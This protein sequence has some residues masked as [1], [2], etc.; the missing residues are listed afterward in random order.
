MPFKC[1]FPGLWGEKIRFLQQIQYLEVKGNNREEEIMKDKQSNNREPDGKR[2]LPPPPVPPSPWRSS[3]GGR[4]MA[5]CSPWGG[6]HTSEYLGPPTP[7]PIQRL[8]E[9][10]AGLAFVLSSVAGPGW[11][12]CVLVPRAGS[13]AARHGVRGPVTSTQ[14][15]ALAH[16]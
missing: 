16:Q 3:T 7:Y 9:K 12:T 4:G 13:T 15:S 14:C 1:P 2:L 10:A 6:C 5:L 8:K 11:Y